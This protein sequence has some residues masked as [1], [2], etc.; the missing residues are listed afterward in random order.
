MDNSIGGEPIGQPMELWTYV[1]YVNPRVVLVGWRYRKTA[2]PELVAR[3]NC[4]TTHKM[5][6]VA[7]GQRKS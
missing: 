5:G 3:I 7:M 4:A 1:E 2:S 6:L